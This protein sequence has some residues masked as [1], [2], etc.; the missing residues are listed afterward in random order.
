MCSSA[1][2]APDLVDLVGPVGSLT[3]LI[4]RFLG[5]V[6]FLLSLVNLTTSRVISIGGLKM[7]SHAL[8]S[9]SDLGK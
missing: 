7:T 8:S 6:V 3:I 5:L 1:G 2:S 4:D 9:G